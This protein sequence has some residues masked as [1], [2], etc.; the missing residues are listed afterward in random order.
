M[1][2]THTIIIDVP[3]LPDIAKTESSLTSH[4]SP[5]YPLGNYVTMDV[6]PIVVSI[7]KGKIILKGSRSKK[8][9]TIDEPKT[10]IQSLNATIGTPSITDR[11][12]L[13]HDS[14]FSTSLRTLTKSI[15]AGYLTNFPTFTANQVN[16]YPPSLLATHKCHLKPIRQNI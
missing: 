14:L 3:S 4:I 10:P 13:Y 8:I 16:I 15:E 11:I 2:S 9:W 6:L 5:S 7:Y 12:K 1:I